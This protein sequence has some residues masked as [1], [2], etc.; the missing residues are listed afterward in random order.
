MTV[1]EAPI[2]WRARPV[3]IGLA[4]MAVAGGITGCGTRGTPR[5][6][7]TGTVTCAGRPVLWGEVT[8]AADATRGNP[9]PGAFAMI[10]NGRYETGRG[11]GVIGGP[12]RVVVSGY[13]GQPGGEGHTGSGRPLFAAWESA[14]DLPRANTTFDIEVPA[15]R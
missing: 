1:R 14:I 8:F 9:G 7:V 11:Q 3:A 13:D 12:M 6:R 15:S 5:Y 10:L 2:R 4:I